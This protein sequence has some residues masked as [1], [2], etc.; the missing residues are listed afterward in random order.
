M[1]LLPNY[2]QIKDGLKYLICE[3]KRTN[4]HDNTGYELGL[5]IGTAE[6]NL[7]K[8]LFFKFYIPRAI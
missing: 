6:W 3:L 8:K 7:S 1:Y 5:L 2:P 4:F